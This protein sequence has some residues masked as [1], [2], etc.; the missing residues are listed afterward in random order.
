[1]NFLNR[2]WWWARIAF[3]LAFIGALLFVLWHIVPIDIG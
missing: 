1:M 2:F 3:V